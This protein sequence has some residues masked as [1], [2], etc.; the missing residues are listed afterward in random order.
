MPVVIDCQATPYCYECNYRYRPYQNAFNDPDLSL[1]AK[2]LWALISERAEGFDRSE[3]LDN[4]VPADLLYDALIELEKKGYFDSSYL[5][6]GI[7]GKQ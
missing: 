6:Y 4:L 3:Y 2:L 5:E 7:G 1:S